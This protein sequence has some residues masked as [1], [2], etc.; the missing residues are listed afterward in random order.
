MKIKVPI[1]STA[2]AMISGFLI[3][4]LRLL[5]G[6]LDSL[7]ARMLQVA[8]AL[9]AVALVVGIANL[10]KVHIEKV[11]E[12]GS[13]AVYSGVLIIALV[14]TFL[15][16]LVLGPTGGV[17]EVEPTNW[18]FQYVQVP[19]EI[20]LVAL[21]AVSLIYA[22]AR[23]LRRDPSPFSFVFL[24]TALLVLLGGS[25]LGTGNFGIISTVFGAVRDWI[26][27]VPAV[28]GA[29]GLLFGVALGAVA[30]GLR[31]LLGT[32]RPFGGS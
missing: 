3:L 21:L 2:V 23:L 22:A 26:V 27:T 29:R 19:I 1:V 7:Y 9:A 28:G 12:G 17:A 31:I 10:I 4:F 8:A 18:L 25:L 5:P 15:A 24:S 32:D 6:G 30:T 11:N 20:S 13:Q 16:A 14:V